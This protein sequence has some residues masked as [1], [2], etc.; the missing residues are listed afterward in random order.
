MFPSVDSILATVR[1]APEWW[2]RRHAIEGVWRFFVYSY[3]WVGEDL[4]GRWDSLKSQLAARRDEVLLTLQLART[5]SDPDVRASAD[6]AITRITALDVV[7]PEIPTSSALLQDYPNPFNPSTT[8]RYN[9]AGQ[10]RITLKVYN[11]LGQEIT[12]L[13]D[14][15]EEA[16]EYQIVWDGRNAFGNRVAT[17]VYFYRLEAKGIAENTSSFV[18]VKKM[19][20]IK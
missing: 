13:V 18:Q 19:L 5:D 16:N 14:D 6:T 17:G 10:A 9:L 3:A 15:V 20:L 1:R 4:N 11:I 12:T 2:V 7:V 8:I